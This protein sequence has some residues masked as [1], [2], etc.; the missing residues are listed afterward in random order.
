MK[1]FHFFLGALAL[2]VATSCSNKK[3]QAD[4]TKVS[5]V[6]TDTVRLASSLSVLQFP[7]K[8]KAAA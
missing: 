6:K 3:K 7:A 4:N 5:I 1:L 2:L 8:V